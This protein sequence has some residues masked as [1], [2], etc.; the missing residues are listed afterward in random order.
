MYSSNNTALIL[1]GGQG[2][3]LKPYTSV[4]PKPLVPVDGKPI[5]E[6]I[7]QKLKLEHKTNSLLIWAKD[8]VDKLL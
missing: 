4:F 6:I 1:A 7:I 5:L 2:T 8:N 3:R